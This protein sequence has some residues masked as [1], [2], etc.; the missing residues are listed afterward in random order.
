MVLGISG[1][2]NQQHLEFGM[3]SPQKIG[4]C[5]HEKSGVPPEVEI[6]KN[7]DGTETD[8]SFTFDPTFDTDF[9]SISHGLSFFPACF[10]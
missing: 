8:R 2:I 7:N 5:N 3:I 9:P 6:S 4:R 1:V 10:P